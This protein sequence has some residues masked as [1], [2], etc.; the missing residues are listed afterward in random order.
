MKIGQQPE[1]S[2][3]ATQ[4][5]QPAIAKAG[6]GTAPAA[7]SERKSAGVGVTV[8]SSARTLES[9]RST[10]TSDVDLEKVNTVRQAIENNTFVV[11]PETI[12]DKLLANAREMLQRTSS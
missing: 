1:I 4:A 3:A 11:N 8:S 2:P 5:I 10:D 6:Q 12:A 9:T 7:K